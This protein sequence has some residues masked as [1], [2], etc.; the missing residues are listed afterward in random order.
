MD[1]SNMCDL[2]EANAEFQCENDQLLDSLD[3]LLHELRCIRAENANL[4]K[5][6]AETTELSVDAKIRDVP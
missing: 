2:L 4:K 6:L 1:A 5:E 3:Q